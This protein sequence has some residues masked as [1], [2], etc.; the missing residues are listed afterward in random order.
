MKLLV[1]LGYNI[2]DMRIIHDIF[3]LG[4]RIRLVDGDD[5]T[6]NTGDRRIK[7]GP[8]PAGSG[9]YGYTLPLP[10]SPGQQPLGD[11]NH[12]CPELLCCEILPFTVIAL[13]PY[14][15]IFRMAGRPAVKQRK[16]IF[17]V[18]NSSSQWT[19]IFLK[20]IFLPI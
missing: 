9:K 20:H 10:E 16:D 17:V 8:F 7:A 12:F 13:I 6:A 14:K 4:R 18:V 5:Y 1:V 2:P 11:R 15:V 3:D 19:C